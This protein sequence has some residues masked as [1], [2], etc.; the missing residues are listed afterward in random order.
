MGLVSSA[1]T[2]SLLGYMP[3]KAA[4]LAWLMLFGITCVLW[5]QAL[6]DQT[7]LKCFSRFF[8]FFGGAEN[9]SSI[10][11]LENPVRPDILFENCCNQW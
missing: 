9:P 2:W 4:E 10:L 1:G 8:F 5:A 11:S 6:R 3:G 7:L